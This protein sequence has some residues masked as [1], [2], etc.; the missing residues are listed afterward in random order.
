MAESMRAGFAGLIAQSSVK[1]T[2]HAL[3]GTRQEDDL[4]VSRLGHGL[5]SLEVS[6]L[7]G[8]SRAKNVGSLS[9]ELGGF[10]LRVSYLSLSSN[11]LAFTNTLALGSHGERLLQLLT[12][13]NILDEH[14]LNL[15]TPASGNILND[16][17][18]GLGDL[19]ATLDD[20]LENTSTDYMTE[21]GL[22]T[23]HE[24]LLNVIDTESSLESLAERVDL[25]QTRIDSLVELSKLCN[26]TDVALV[27]FLVRVGADDTAGNGAH[28][29]NDASKDV[30]CW[31]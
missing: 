16:F 9:H 31:G 18:D 10:D 26:E 4:A 17:S 28:G 2:S 30:H 3:A 27:D 20:V 19:L 21:S 22:S 5:H 1:S 7:H 11:D 25:D 14:T 12:E 8:R 6:D 24:S 13:D 23:L 15:N 29:S